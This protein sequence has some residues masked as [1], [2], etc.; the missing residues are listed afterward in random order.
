MAE[1]IGVIWIFWLQLFA[2]V[3]AVCVYLTYLTKIKW[4]YGSLEW[5]IDKVYY[6]RLNIGGVFR[7]IYFDYLF[8]IF[9]K[10]DREWWEVCVYLCVFYFKICKIISKYR[11]KVKELLTRL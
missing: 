1:K 5:M 2:E 6:F 10:M 3:C 4:E 11:F 8:I 7:I 9:Y